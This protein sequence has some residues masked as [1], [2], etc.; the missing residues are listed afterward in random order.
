MMVMVHAIFIRDC[1][2][3]TAVFIDVGRSYYIKN[4]AVVD[5]GWG[6]GFIVLCFEYMLCGQGFNL[7]NDI[8]FFNDLF[9]GHA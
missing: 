8:C 7:R 5:V 4:A 1:Q 2:R 3:W 6:V 9:M